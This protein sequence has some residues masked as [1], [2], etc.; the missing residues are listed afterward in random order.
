MRAARPVWSGHNNDA[1]GTFSLEAEQTVKQM[2]IIMARDPVI[3]LLGSTV[4]QPV[5]ISEV[6]S[7]LKNF[8]HSVLHMQKTSS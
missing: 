3:T 5:G 6:V 7:R 2:Q 8:Y 4:V 1:F